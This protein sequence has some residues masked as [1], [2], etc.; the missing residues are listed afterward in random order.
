MQ[1]LIQA[2]LEGRKFDTLGEA[3]GAVEEILGEG[4]TVDGDGYGDD[5]VVWASPPATTVQV[6]GVFK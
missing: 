5:L 6:K 2:A 3:L 1:D 4:F